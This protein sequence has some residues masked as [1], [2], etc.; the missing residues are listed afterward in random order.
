MS[1]RFYSQA[2]QD[3][4]VL[5]VLCDKRDGTFVDCGCCH[6]VEISNS[7]AL[8][9]QFGWNGVLLD[10]DPGAIA[11]CEKM[12]TSPSIL[13]DAVAADW[14]TIF[15]QRFPDG[16]PI[17]FLSL[18]IDGATPQ[19]LQAVLDPMR[20][21]RVITVEHDQYLPGGGERRT[22]VESLLVSRGYDLL[23]RN[24]C[25]K[26]GL[27]FEVWAVDPKLVDMAKAER[28]RSDGLRWN[29]ILART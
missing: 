26:E 6:P 9:S 2:A 24:V 12:R 7:Y 20:R 16:Q 1:V 8:E 18:D 28:F 29:E 22:A 19:A 11:L 15:E 23:C 10:N 25:S 13:G 14:A 5:A 4:F 27:S 3:R 21:F 17:D